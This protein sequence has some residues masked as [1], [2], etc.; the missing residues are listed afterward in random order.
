MAGYVMFFVFGPTGPVYHITK[1][2][3]TK[4]ILAG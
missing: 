1:I 3:M 4:N 2:K